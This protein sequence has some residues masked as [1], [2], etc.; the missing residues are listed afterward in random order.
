ML[1]FLSY[2]AGTIRYR[3]KMQKSLLDYDVTGE[4]PPLVIYRTIS[5]ARARQRARD[6]YR[7]LPKLLM[8]EDEL[9]IGGQ[10]FRSQLSQKMGEF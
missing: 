5:R 9:I 8:A 2:L 7:T 6:L 1:D 10:D 4:S 3:G